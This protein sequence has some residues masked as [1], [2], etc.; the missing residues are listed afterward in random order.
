[1]TDEDMAI[2]ADFVPGV[3]NAD[4]YMPTRHWV[5]NALKTARIQSID[6]MVYR[7]KVGMNSLDP[8][9]LQFPCWPYEDGH[10][11]ETIDPRIMI[12]ATVSS[13][14]EICKPDG[15]ADE[16]LAEFLYGQAFTESWWTAM[17]TL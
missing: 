15:L 14:G 4:D 12:L 7:L 16:I 11:E 8:D 1:M 17:W 9:S 10:E 3:V 13:N 5:Y 2:R 6:G